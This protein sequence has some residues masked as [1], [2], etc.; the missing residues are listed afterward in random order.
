MFKN[1]T[2]NERNR[3][4]LKSF[5]GENLNSS[6]ESKKFILSLIRQNLKVITCK[7]G[8]FAGIRARPLFVVSTYSYNGYPLRS[9]F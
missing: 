8:D 1:A 3:I 9:L 2:V 5:I 4:F 7:A 6:T